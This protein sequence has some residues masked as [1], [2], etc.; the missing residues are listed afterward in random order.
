VDLQYAALECWKA[1][2]TLLPEELILDSINFQRGRTLSVSGHGPEGAGPRATDYNEALR[3][4]LYKGEKIFSKV[5]APDIRPQ[6]NEGIRWT[7]TAE[8]K[9]AN[10][11]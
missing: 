8:L 6:P 11:E 9:R 3:N 7:L 5:L 1:V 2:A 4:A 10:L